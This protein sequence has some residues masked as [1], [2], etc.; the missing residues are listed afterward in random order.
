MSMPA[1]EPHSRPSGSGAQF[2]ITSPVGFGSG[3]ST[4][5]LSP[6]CAAAI[7][8]AATTNTAAASTM[9]ARVDTCLVLL[10]PVLLVL[11]RRPADPAGPSTYAF[12]PQSKCTSASAMPLSPATA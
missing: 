2:R 3:R 5:S 1:V 10:M 12:T 11:S 6:F 8:A 9:P 4:Q 7:E